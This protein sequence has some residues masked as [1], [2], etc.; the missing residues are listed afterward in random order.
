MVT[1]YTYA[2]TEHPSIPNKTLYVQ[3]TDLELWERAAE[4][5]PNGNMS[6]FVAAAIRSEIRRLEA[7]ITEAE[8]TKG[9]EP[10]EVEVGT[11]TSGKLQRHF[12]GRWLVKDEPDDE[13]APLWNEGAYSVRWTGSVAQMRNGRLLVWSELMDWDEL[14]D[15]YRADLRIVA[16]IQ[17]LNRLAD[18]GVI[19]RRLVDLTAVKLNQPIDISD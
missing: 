6:A 17:E 1:T 3:P 11:E 5:A 18:E 10:I 2:H 8:A 4:L 7:A 9:F 12:V 15:D 13:F 14:D 16:N 19:S